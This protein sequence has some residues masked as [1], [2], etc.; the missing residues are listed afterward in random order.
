MPISPYKGTTK[1]III[2]LESP[3]K[4]RSVFHIIFR[5]LEVRIKNL[6]VSSF[7]STFNYS[8]KLLQKLS[9]NYSH[10]KSL[11]LGPHS[12][13]NLQNFHRKILVQL[14]I[15]V[16]PATAESG[17]F[18]ETHIRQTPLLPSESS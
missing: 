10:I 2:S 11:L 5:Y 4:H 14:R 9:I 6:G 17:Y 1:V 8:V 13:N 3:I 16:D 18:L 15:S 7:L 12:P